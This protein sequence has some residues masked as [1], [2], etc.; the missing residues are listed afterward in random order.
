MKITKKLIKF[1]EA[2][3]KIYGTEAAIFNLLWLQAREQL[4]D[5]GV[6]DLK[7]TLRKTRGKP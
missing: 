3:Q 5:I 1:F 4:Y 6:K 7:T 2:D